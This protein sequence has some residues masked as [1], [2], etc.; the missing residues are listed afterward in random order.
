MIRAS[1]TSSSKI[2]I[3]RGSFLRVVAI[4]LACSGAGLLTNSVFAESGLP[5]TTAT[6]AQRCF[7]FEQGPLVMTEDALRDANG[8]FSLAQLPAPEPKC[9]VRLTGNITPLT[10]RMWQIA[11]ADVER[12]QV[13]HESGVVYFGAGSRYGDRVY[14]RDISI[15]GVLGVNRF[16][17]NGMLA[18][19]K[20]TREI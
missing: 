16:Y 18:S 15:A 14:T 4:G 9:K 17:P 3:H 2:Q 12:N 5:P 6:K 13:K 10:Q 8:Q 20:L 1:I 19:L 11:L 7:L